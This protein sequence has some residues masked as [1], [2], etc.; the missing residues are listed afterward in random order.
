VI[1]TSGGLDKLEVYRKLGVREVWHWR[2]GRIEIHVLRGE[3]YQP[4][5]ASE[6]LA[7]I[8]LEQLASFLDRVT[9][10]QAIR[11]YRDALRAGST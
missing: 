8:D 10:S 2:H 4:A 11:E 7:G 9:T 1:W 3:H 6:A 5:A